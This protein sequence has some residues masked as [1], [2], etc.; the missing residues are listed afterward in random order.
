MP[1]L[2][3]VVMSMVR[4]LGWE[5]QDRF[6]VFMGALLTLTGPF[7]L[8][9]CVLA[10][11]PDWTVPFVAFGVLLVPYFVIARHDVGTM[12]WSWFLVLSTLWT[13][14]CWWMTSTWSA[15]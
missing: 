3:Y 2:V 15:R 11:L 14:G 10:W 9:F 6:E 4:A 12:P 7:S 1:V 8:C 5:N 13:G